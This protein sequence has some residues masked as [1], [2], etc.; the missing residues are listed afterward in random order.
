MGPSSGLL[1]PVQEFELLVV[2]ERLLKKWQEFNVCNEYWVSTLKRS[3][4]CVI[5]SC[6]PRWTPRR[7]LR[8]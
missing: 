8:R 3:P 7:R 4:L 1:H 2:P 5:T 6:V